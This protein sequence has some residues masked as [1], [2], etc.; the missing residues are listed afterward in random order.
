MRTG[1]VR[2]YRGRSSTRTSPRSHSS[3]PLRQGDVKPVTLLL[4]LAP[5][6][7]A[8]CGPRASAKPDRPAPTPTPKAPVVLPA[9]APAADPNC[10]A[11]WTCDYGALARTKDLSITEIL[12]QKQAHKLHLV[13]GKTIV[14][15][16]GMAMGNG[17][18]GF[19]RFEGDRV[20]PVGVYSITGRYPSRW[21]TYLALSY[22][23][24]DDRRRFAALVA[25]GEVDAKRGPGSAIAIHGHRADQSET[26]H[27]LRD[28]TLGCVALDNDEIDEIARAAPVGTKVV[29]ED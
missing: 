14:K 5:A 8:A 10:P 4:A 17:G 15:S 9:P 19:K 3:R 11:A 28:W 13:A 12:V 21:H 22:P 24:D 23:N 26:L 20:T 25:R 27:K 29:I 6:L 2:G 18:L 7:L 16:Y 1:S